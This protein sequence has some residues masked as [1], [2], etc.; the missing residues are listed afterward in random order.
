[1][2]ISLKN[3]DIGGIPTFEKIVK[4]HHIDICLFILS[5]LLLEKI[6]RLSE[7][8]YIRPTRRNI[9]EETK[10]CL[11]V[12]SMAPIKPFVL[13]D[14]REFVVNPMWEIDEIAAIFLI[15][16]NIIDQIIQIIEQIQEIDIIIPLELDKI[17]SIINEFFNKP[18]IPSFN[19]NLAKIIDPRV[20]AST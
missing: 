17:S 6:L 5:I 11:I 15:S 8:S 12:I 4:I 7:F 13:N 19:I 10:P 2:K 1:M 18:K 20:D 14:K 3:L 16:A 9:T